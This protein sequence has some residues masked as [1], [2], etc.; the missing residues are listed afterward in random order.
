MERK[1]VETDLRQNR[2]IIFQLCLAFLV[3]LVVFIS[4]CSQLPSEPSPE[5]TPNIE[6]ESSPTPPIFTTGC[7]YT[8]NPS[9]SYINVKTVKPGEG[10]LVY[11]DYGASLT[12]CIN[13]EAP[14]PGCK[15]TKWLKTT[16]EF[17]C[18]AP[19]TQQTVDINCKIKPTFLCDAK[20]CVTQKIGTINIESETTCLTPDP[21]PEGGSQPIIDTKDGCPVFGS[22]PSP[23]PEKSPFVA[24]PQKPEIS[25]LKK[26]SSLQ[27]TQEFIKR[28]VESAYGGA[29]GRD[30][31]IDAIQPLASI[32][33]ITSAKSTSESTPD[34]S[35]TNIQVEGVDEADIVKTDGKYIYT[36]SDRK[37][38]VIVEAYPAASAKN[39]STIEISGNVKEIFIN[40]DKLVVFGTEYIEEKREETMPITGKLIIPSDYYSR[41]YKD[42]LRVYNITNR[43]EPTLKTNIQFNGTYFDSRMI[44]SWV[45]FVVNKRAY[46]DDVA[47][48]INIKCLDAKGNCPLLTT[49]Y[50][51]DVPA[52]SY[53]LTSVGAL[54][55]EGSEESSV[56]TFLLSYTEEM[57]VSLDNIYVTHRKKINRNETIED[58]LAAARQTMPSHVTSKIE[59]ITNSPTYNGSWQQLREV[60]DTIYNYTQS[61]R[62]QE[63]EYKYNSEFSK[64]E[65]KRKRKDF[66]N[67][68]IEDTL[69][70]SRQTMPSHVTSKIEAI[71]NSPTY[72][73]SW[74]QLREV[75]DIIYNYIRS[76]QEQ[77]E[78][79]K[80]RDKYDLELSSIREKR[81]T[82]RRK[83][84][85]ENKLAASRQTMPSH[86]T[87][88]IEAITNSP[89]YNSSWQQ[90]REVE[91]IIYNY[92]RSIREQQESWKVIDK[93]DSEFSKLES[94]R[95]KTIVYKISIYG[96]QINLVAQGEFPGHLLNQFS[97]DEFNGYF[98]AAATTGGFWGNTSENN[99]YVMGEDLKIAGKVEGLALGE[100]IYSARFMGERVYLVTFK[101]IDPL[102]VIDLKDPT[103]PKVLGKLKIPGYSDYLHPYDQNH[104]IGVGKETLEVNGLVLLQGVKLALFNVTDPENP[105]EVSKYEIGD[106]GTDSY[107]LRDHKA[108]LFNKDRELL[109]IPVMLVESSADEKANITRFVYGNR[110]F[111]GAYIF[112][113][114]KEKGFVLKG[115]ITHVQDTGDLKKPG[116]YYF[117]SR[118]LV[119]RS[120][121]IGNVLYTISDAFVKANNIAD[122]KE[123]KSIELIG[124][125]YGPVI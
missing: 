16:A 69:A 42:F 106:M 57:F 83:E 76:I 40:K 101:Q 19:S 52:D 117:S 10:Y 107:A 9:R 55:L 38:V 98:R 35:K 44:G 14:L 43:S 8:F 70:A 2:K 47:L 85:I 32:V 27:E 66:V 64:L 111:Q 72:N 92:T 56:K 41:K 53:V 96:S 17:S 49:I 51:I 11:C 25:S 102:F 93:Y 75:E 114:T 90:L 68:T 113:L 119:K 123:L 59:A 122:L 45:Y 82:V 6:A 80:I 28:N 86:V 97:M 71:T 88:K 7:Q 89:T 112:N 115:R 79:R 61:I 33:E 74:Q 84:T 124:P 108:F 103:N 105:K 118:D 110:T 65:S 54:N 109:I 4:G 78:S 77:Q 50:Y 23:T 39:L 26:F 20:D 13:I 100:R 21:C 60:E 1:E 62:E 87:S 22:C 91:N 63:I 58:K 34:F 125:Y 36:V 121:Y 99:V 94:K 67:E 120:L 31:N 29:Y 48:P 81:E 73:S 95:Q 116:Y 46:R 15:F 5:T 3:I 30:V 24:K 12:D 37:R 104:I 18:I